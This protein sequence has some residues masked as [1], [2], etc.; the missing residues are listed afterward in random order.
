MRGCS[1]NILVSIL[2]NIWLL[3]TNRL[4]RIS[5][6]NS[7]NCALRKLYIMTNK[8][9]SFWII[10]GGLILAASC[11]KIEGT[12]GRASITGKVFAINLTN[13]LVLA[14]DSGYASGIDVYLTYGNSNLIGE[15]AETGINGEFEFPY[16]QKGSYK[17]YAISKQLNGANK[18]DT[19]V[20][21]SAIINDKSQKVNVG[22]LRI[23]VSKN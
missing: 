9:L 16:L 8:F 11:K 15:K 4:L 1:A 21:K 19:T 22:D 13:S 23:Y 17:V 12:G 20:I 2:L 10:A 3:S 18:L 5:T 7:V 14:T 6:E